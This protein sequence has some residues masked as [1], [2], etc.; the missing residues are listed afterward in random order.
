MD[1]LFEPIVINNLE[2]K[3]RIYM[4]A[5]H[6]NMAKN[7]FV[8]EKLIDF[9]HERAK[10]GVGMIT[11]GYATVDELS[12]SGGFIGAHSDEY[13][14]GL[15]KL[16]HTIKSEG[17]KSCVQL[18]HAGRYMHSFLL[19]GKQ[20]VA[21]SAIASKFTKETPRELTVSEIKTIIQKF[22]EAAERV[23]K[24]GFDAVE[25]LSGTGYLISE[26]LS[27]LTNKRSDEYG[28]S[29]ENRARFGLEIMQAIR[30]KVGNDFPLIVRIN[31]NDLMEGGLSKEEILKYAKRLEEVGVDALNVNVG[32]HEAM[33]PQIVTKVPRGV[34]AYLARAVKEVVSLPVIACHRIND[35]QTAREL[36]ENGFCDMVSMGRALIADPYLP[37]K[38]LEG[39]EKEIIH[40]TACAQGCFDNLF[41][42][43]SVECLCNP[44]A[45]HEAERVVEKT[46]K[47]LKV[48]VVGGGAAGMYAALTAYEAGHNVILCEK[49]NELGGQ[50]NIAGVPNGREEFKVLAEDLIMQVK[51][52]GVVVKL[53]TAVTEDLLKE[54]KPDF[55]IIATGALPIKP[56][57]KGVDMP[58]VFD[59]WD[60]LK[61]KVRVGKN[62]VIIGGGA[63]G[64][65]TALFL[66]E[67]G[68]LSPE[69]VKFLLVHRVESP[70][71]LYE[72]SVKGTKNVTIIEMLDEIGTNFGKTTRWVMLQDLYRHKVKVLTGKK[73][74]EITEKTVLF[75]DNGNTGEIAADSV[76]LAV[77]SR[78][79]NPLE[80]I[81]LKA[82]IKYKVVGDAAK[83]GFAFDAIHSGFEAARKIKAEA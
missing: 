44:R 12:G 73:V 62:I 67:K 14:E 16:A 59:A 51:K 35:P 25:V 80:E 23:K 20:P 71:Y 76:I 15:K 63:V 11:V 24:A 26:F 9:Y 34:Y 81:V 13:L 50:L 61:G 53:N 27:T 74:T 79:Y 33:I 38:V 40:C 1:I 49:D 21:P 8:T 28:G 4:P 7:Y 46:E 37:K 70:E 2:I 55:V 64:V 68:T 65:E 78:S 60:V 72:L 39:R 66:A 5:M 75:S 54:E 3:N 77:G 32:W 22:A 6:L 29:F 31:G 47:P 56:P 45:G 69:A 41:K 19:G 83:V 36:I 42:M 57:I 17:A 48:M 18:N 30:E 10:G 52:S 82:G 43:K 58:H